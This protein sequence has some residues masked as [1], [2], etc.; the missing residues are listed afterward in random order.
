MVTSDTFEAKNRR[1][2][3]G[4]MTAH[5]WATQPDRHNPLA[6]EVGA[7]FSRSPIYCLR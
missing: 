6:G 5:C 7:H 2:R 1:V 4:R 3:W